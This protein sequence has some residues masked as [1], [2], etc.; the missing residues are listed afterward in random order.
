MTTETSALLIVDVQR[1]FITPQS[2]H[3]VA[4]IE[5]LQSRFGHVVVTRFINPPGSPFRD[6]LNYDKFAP[7]S[8]EVELAFTPRPDALII[9]RPLYTG[10][11]PDLLAALQ[12][13]GLDEVYVAGIATE[14]CVLKTL[15]DLFE[16]HITPW[17]IE[18]LCASDKGAEFHDPAI[19]VIGK[20]ID[21]GHIIRLADL[22]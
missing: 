20:L 10:V 13:W 22:G 18:D 21:P 6:L 15:T 5:A 17:M 11:T 16:R 7:G 1:G 3:V 2:A 19:K 8:A 9:D 4:P 14:A 12:G